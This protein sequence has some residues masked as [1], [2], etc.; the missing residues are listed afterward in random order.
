MSYSNE[1]SDFEEWLRYGEKHGWLK[2]MPKAMSPDGPRTDEFIEAEVYD[3]LKHNRDIDASDIDVDVKEGV[4][5][6]RGFVDNKF[7]RQLAAQLVQQITG[8]KLIKNALQ[9][10]QFGFQPG[11]TEPSELPQELPQERA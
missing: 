1:R 2:N 6:L 3:K 10:K 9:Y 4:V 11:I 8:V 7:E 5:T